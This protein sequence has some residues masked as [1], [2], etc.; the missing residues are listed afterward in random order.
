[1]EIISPVGGGTTL[2][3]EIPSD[4]AVSLD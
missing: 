4:T 2:R 3:A 1:M